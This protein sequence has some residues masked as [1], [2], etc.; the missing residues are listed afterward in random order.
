MEPV[1]IN[2]TSGSLQLHSWSDEMF[3]QLQSSHTLCAEKYYTP[4]DT[5]IKPIVKNVNL[6]TAIIEFIVWK[7][8]DA[9][10][11]V[12]NHAHFFPF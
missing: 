11:C 8:L 7:K 9:M 10:I 6:W 12:V 3:Q 4:S 1:W 5:Q 2:T